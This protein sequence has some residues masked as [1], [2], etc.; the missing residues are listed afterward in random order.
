MLAVAVQ[1]AVA[2][3]AGTALGQGAAGNSSGRDLDQLLHLAAV[4]GPSHMLLRA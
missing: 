1:Q 3:A 2:G 4:E